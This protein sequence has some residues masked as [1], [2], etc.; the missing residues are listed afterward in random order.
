LDPNE[1]RDLIDCFLVER[2]KL[3]KAGDPD[4]AIYQGGSN[5]EI[6]NIEEID[7]K[8]GWICLKY[9]VCN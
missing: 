1:S 9:P 5:S 2:A 6:R 7:G 3:K 4:E 8:L